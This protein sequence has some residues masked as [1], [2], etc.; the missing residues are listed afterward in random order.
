M[1]DEPTV[2]K[3]NNGHSRLEACASKRNLIGQQPDRPRNVCLDVHVYRVVGPEGVGEAL[4]L[5]N[6]NE[7]RPLPLRADMLCGTF[8]PP[9]ACSPDMVKMYS[10]VNGVGERGQVHFLA[11]ALQN[12]GGGASTLHNVRDNRPR[13]PTACN[14][15]ESQAAAPPAP[16]KAPPP[17]P[18]DQATHRCHHPR[19]RRSTA[20]PLLPPAMAHGHPLEW[21]CLVLQRVHRAK[22]FGVRPAH[23]PPMPPTTPE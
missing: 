17:P 5:R 15:E 14:P 7:G 2:A 12:L 3:P 16:D 10:A 9:L 18:S 23:R 1:D 20:R 22:S 8:S 19:A 11:H 6:R 13:F 21:H 4:L